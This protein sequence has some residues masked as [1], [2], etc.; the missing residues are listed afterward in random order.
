MEF[1]LIVNILSSFTEANSQAPV[2]NPAMLQ[3]LCICCVNKSLSG[4]EPGASPLGW[5]MGGGRAQRGGCREGFGLQCW[6]PFGRAVPFSGIRVVC[7]LL[8]PCWLL[9]PYEGVC[10]QASGEEA[11]TAE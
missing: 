3:Q 4:A 10:V 1:C 7:A 11:Q 6:V 5:L 2:R 9:L 8:A